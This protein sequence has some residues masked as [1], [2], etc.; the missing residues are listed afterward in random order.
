[1]FEYCANIG[2]QP[3]FD[4]IV[5]KNRFEAN[6]ASEGTISEFRRLCLFESKELVNPRQ[7]QGFKFWIAAVI[8]IIVMMRMHGREKFDNSATTALE[9][10][11]TTR[12]RYLLDGIDSVSN[13]NELHRIIQLR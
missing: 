5:E 12:Y 8:N 13:L 3:I 6:I 10:I 1:M 7:Y 2:D 11:S 9:Q 4:S